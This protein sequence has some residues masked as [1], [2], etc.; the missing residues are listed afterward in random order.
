[1]RSPFFYVALHTASFWG[2]IS[3]AAGKSLSGKYL[4]DVGAW[5]WPITAFPL[6][7]DCVFT[8]YLVINATPIVSSYLRRT[9]NL[10]VAE[11][12]SAINFFYKKQLASMY[13]E[14]GPLHGKKRAGTR[15][16]I[17]NN[18]SVGWPYPS[19]ARPLCLFSLVFFTGNRVLREAK[20]NWILRC[21][22][23]PSPS[24]GQKR[25]LSKCWSNVAGWCCFLPAREL[26]VLQSGRGVEDYD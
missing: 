8:V 23:A 17:Q 11:I 4:T 25:G 18:I 16:E 24:L 21:R 5:R 2:L 19:K 22:F 14:S 20:D 7:A 10:V 1:M 12:Q 6:G 13:T 3:Y 15:R 9:T 26:A